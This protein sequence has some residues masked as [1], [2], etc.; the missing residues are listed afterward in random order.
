M[1]DLIDTAQEQEAVFLT[2]ALSKRNASLP[3]LNKC[4]WCK[5]PVGAKAHFCDADC[6][7]DFEQNRRL[8]GGF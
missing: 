3:Y 7:H 2:A 5:D 8:N 6:R 4:H 1:A